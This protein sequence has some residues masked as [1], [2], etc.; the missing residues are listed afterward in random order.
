[1]RKPY[2]IGSLKMFLIWKFEIIEV[3]ITPVLYKK[4][5]CIK[6]MIQQYYKRLLKQEKG[7]TARLTR[8]FYVCIKKAKVWNE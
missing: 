2:N 3:I 8:M 1:M 7:V 5:I 6:L 4:F